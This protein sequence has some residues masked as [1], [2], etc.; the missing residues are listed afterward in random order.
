MKRQKDFTQIKHYGA[1][2]A[3]NHSKNGVSSKSQTN[4]KNLLNIW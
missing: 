3:R 1:M 4:R 2:E